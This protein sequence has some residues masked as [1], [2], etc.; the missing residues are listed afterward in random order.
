MLRFPYFFTEVIVSPTV[1]CLLQLHS[2]LLQPLVPL[3]VLLMTQLSRQGP[4]LPAVRCPWLLPTN[5]A[6]SPHPAA[7]AG[8][9]SYCIFTLQ[10]R[11][12]HF[13]PWS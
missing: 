6:L 10:M 12:L 9:P 8:I 5:K 1:T 4:S 7:L 2:P 3:L 11:C 13:I